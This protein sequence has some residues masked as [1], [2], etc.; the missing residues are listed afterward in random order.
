M[1]F[2]LLM[3]CGGRLP[4]VASDWPMLG[5]SPER[6]GS[7]PD[8]VRPPFARK[9]YR[10]FPDE[11]LM[12]GVQP[13]V[14]GGKVFVGTLR[15][16][17]HAM[18]GDTGRDVWSFAAG[19]PVLHSC[20][21]AGGR[22]LFGCADGKFYAVDIATGELAWNVQTPA[23]I[24]N[25]PVAVDGTALVGSRDGTL[26]ACALADG[27]VRWRAATPR[28]LLCSPA[29]DRGAGACT[30]AAKTCTCTPLTC[31]AAAGC[32]RATSCPASAY[33]ATIRSWPRTVR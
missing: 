29:V 13:V 31:R 22:L 9:W 2:W 19:G 32:G 33:A 17:V 12:T 16:I 30:W 20:A 14:A 18:D 5:C 6:D 11:G 25:A 27:S 28:P 7:T 8:E 10:A 15:G 3:T 1:L 26:Y 23:A 21:A 24:W 4:A